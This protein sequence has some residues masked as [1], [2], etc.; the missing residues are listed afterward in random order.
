MRP[1]NLLP[2]SERPRAT[3]AAP[4]NASTIVLVVLAV[5]VVAIAG[6]VLTKNQATSK[7]AEIA[8]ASQEQAQAEQRAGGLKAYGDFSQIKQ[9]RVDAVTQLATQRFDWERLMRELALVVPDKV[10]LT[11]VTATGTGAAA[12]AGSPS[13][14]STSTPPAATSGSTADATAGSGGPSVKV[15]GCA[16]SQK[17]VAETMVRLR[18]LYGAQEV[19][20]QDSTAPQDQKGGSAP[21][22]SAS[23]GSP[24]GSGGCVSRYQFES[25]V[26]FAAP[27]AAPTV[28]PSRVPT[29][30]GGGA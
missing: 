27:D 9:T 2:P 18:S 15:S 7:R 25:T 29:R 22:P 24:S 14:S 11:D 4:Q 16:P 20:L 26:T 3:V 12:S 13:P 1:V 19:D 30:L 23:S 6:L 17:V 21:P 8:K 5:L 28:K 10:W